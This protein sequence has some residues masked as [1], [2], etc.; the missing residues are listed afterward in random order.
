MKKQ[1]PL[2]WAVCMTLYTSLVSASTCVPINPTVSDSASALTICSGTPVTFTATDSNGTAPSYQ[3]YKNGV[4]VGMDTSVYTNAALNN[5]DSIW[6]VMTSTTNCGTLATDTSNHL[7]I[8]VNPTPSAPAISLS[9]GVC[10]GSD[11]IGAL[12]TSGATHIIWQLNGSPVD[13]QSLAVDTPITILH[14]CPSPSGQCLGGGYLY[15]A[16]QTNNAIYKFPQGTINASYA[17]RAAG[18]MA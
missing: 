18:A 17:P 7:V 12:V 16:D 15:I 8:T 14:I 2:F 11:S 3:W 9:G 13:T 10:L 6:V 1:V 4:A 5:N